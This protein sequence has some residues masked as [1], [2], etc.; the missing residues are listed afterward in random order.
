MADG[1]TEKPKVW[2]LD[3]IVAD[4]DGWHRSTLERI[5]RENPQMTDEQI[6]NAWQFA[7]AQF[8]L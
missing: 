2:T 8:G 1:P 5:R 3:E 6:E 7:K 4:P